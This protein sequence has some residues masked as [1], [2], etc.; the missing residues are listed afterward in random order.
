MT[1][2]AAAPKLPEIWETATSTSAVLKST[3]SK[4]I[5]SK[6]VDVP[7][8]ATVPM[9][10]AKKAEMKSRNIISSVMLIIM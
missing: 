8:P 3:K 7:N 1:K 10:T 2:N 9:T 4:V 5:G 6:I